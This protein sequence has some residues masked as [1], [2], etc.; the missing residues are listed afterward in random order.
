MN[1]SYIDTIVLSNCHLINRADDLSPTQLRLQWF[2]YLM[3][4]DWIPPPLVRWVADKL[5]RTSLQAFARL[6]KH[7]A[8]S[9]VEYDYLATLGDQVHGIAER[10][11]YGE[12]G[13]KVMREFLE[14]CRPLARATLLH[15]PSEHPLGYPEGVDYVPNVR[16]GNG[17]PRISIEMPRDIGGRMDPE[18]IANWQELVGPLFG[19][20]EVMSWKFIWLD[21]DLFRWR[22][23]AHYSKDGFLMRLI[24]EQDA[25]LERELADGTSGRI[26]VCSH[27]VNVVD[28]PIFMAHADRIY[29][30]IFGDFHYKKMAERG[31]R[32]HGPFPFQTWFVPALWGFQ[33]GVGKSGYGAMRITADDIAY[34]ERYL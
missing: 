22:S 16:W 23:Q 29:A 7:L 10:G 19:S 8:L 17:R 1:G 32:Q 11:I 2:P 3:A 27:R 20:T 6:A 14:L 4:R 21:C 24:A 28:H 13:R 31:L 12:A 15:T 9:G 34:E 18:A 30:V 25:F 5:R 33:F 26:V